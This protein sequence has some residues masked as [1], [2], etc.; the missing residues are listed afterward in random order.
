M[1]ETNFWGAM[2]KVRP[3][4]TSFGPNYEL[5]PKRNNLQV[6]FY[7][8]SRRR[9]RSQIDLRADLSLLLSFKLIA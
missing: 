1:M 2:F 9:T 6:C 3:V 8:W 7:R 4:R 5:L